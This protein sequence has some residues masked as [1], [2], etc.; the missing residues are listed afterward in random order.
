MSRTLTFEQIASSRNNEG[1]NA[2]L[3][4]HNKIMELLTSHESITVKHGDVTENFWDKN[5]IRS[6]EDVTDYRIRYYVKK[7][8]R[9]ITWNDIYKMVNSVKAAP[10][11]FL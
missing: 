3:D 2:L 4:R 8:G 10:Y 9:K 5:L 11:D 7:Q 6:N 1:K